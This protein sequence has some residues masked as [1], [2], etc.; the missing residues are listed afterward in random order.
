MN[1][2]SN[3]SEDLKF[4]SVFPLVCIMTIINMVLIA[5]LHLLPVV[6]TLTI[7]IVNMVLIATL[8]LLPVATTLTIT[9]VNMV[10]IATLHLLPVV[11]TLSLSLQWF[12]SLL[13]FSF[14][15]CGYHAYYHYNNHDPYHLR[16]ICFLWL[17]RLLLFNTI[18]GGNKYRNLALQVGG[19]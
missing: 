3:A 15:S 7:T 14:A 12:L 9:I 13:R 19:T 10:L 1:S 18:P 11:T 5:T 6:T 16:F 2:L 8:H 17:P 4:V